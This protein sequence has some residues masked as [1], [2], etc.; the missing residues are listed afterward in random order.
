MPASRRKQL[1]KQIEDLRGSKVLTYVTSNRENITSDIESDDIEHFRK[2]LDE[3]CTKCKEIDLFLFSYG[4]EIEAA[5]ELVSLL[6]EYNVNFNVLIPYHA[7]SAATMIA[8]GAKEIIMG[9][10]ASLGPIDPTIR[11]RGGELGGMQISVSDID[12]FEDFLREEYQVTDPEDKMEA[13]KMLGENV[14][15]VLLGKAYR[16]YLETRKDAQK[17]LQHHI[18]N[19]KKIKKIVQLFIKDISTHNHSISRPEAKQAGLNVIYPD[20]KLETLMWDLYK[21]YVS[22]MSMDKAYVDAPPHNKTSLEVIFTTIES[23]RLSTKKTGKI[24][25]KKLDFPKGTHLISVD[26][27][28]AVYTPEGETI[29]LIPSGQLIAANKYIYDKTEEIIW[30]ENALR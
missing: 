23:Y 11:I 13:L 8:M 15:P 20:K 28:Q 17:L 12:S 19:P 7:R 22:F 18:N 4:G 29:P 25:F 1:I 3:I 21:E 14:S 16:N 2:H 10:M 9:K 27:T 30:I 24:N 6:R 26:D 5:W